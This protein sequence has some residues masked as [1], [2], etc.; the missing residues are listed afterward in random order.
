MVLLPPGCM[1]IDIF[2]TVPNLELTFMRRFPGLWKHPC[3]ER[4]N[5]PYHITNE[6]LTLCQVTQTLL[7]MI[8]PY[9]YY[10]K[11][12]EAYRNIYFCS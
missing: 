1:A 8:Y 5:P 6:R 7:S 3:K 2:K 11:L 10:E 12:E 9:L 4:E